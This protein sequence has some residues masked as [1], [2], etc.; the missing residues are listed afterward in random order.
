MEEHCQTLQSLNLCPSASLVVSKPVLP[1]NG[2]N[3]IVNKHIM[4]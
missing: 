1:E 3:S 4:C 2:K